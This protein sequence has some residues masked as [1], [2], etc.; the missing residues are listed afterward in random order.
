MDAMDFYFSFYTTY[1]EIACA[2]AAPLTPICRTKINI[3]S[4]TTFIPSPITTYEKHKPQMN[5][6]G[7]V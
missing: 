2:M 1:C 7:K 3:G 4:K 5:V 6:K